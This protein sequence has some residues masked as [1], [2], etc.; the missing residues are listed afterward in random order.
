MRPIQYITDDE[1]FYFLTRP[2]ISFLK[3]NQR[4]TDNQSTAALLAIQSKGGEAL[5]HLVST[6]HD[7]IQ[8]RCT[9][10][11]KWGVRC[12]LSQG[13]LSRMQERR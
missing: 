6:S 3:R 12:L 9:Q 13:M 5:R 11:S 8:A 10:K 4:I 1:P 7:Y 2:H